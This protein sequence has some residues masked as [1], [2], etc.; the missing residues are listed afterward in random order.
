VPGGTSTAALPAGP[1]ATIHTLALVDT[2]GYAD[3]AACAQRLDA[4]E[5][6]HLAMPLF[7]SPDEFSSSLD[8]FP[9][10]YGAIISSHLALVGDDPFSGIAVQ[11]D[12]VRRA[13][14]VQAKSHVIHLREGFLQAGGSGLKVSRLIAHSISSFHTLLTNLA[15]LDRQDASTMDA[16]ARYAESHAGLSASLVSRLL[17]LPERDP[18]TADEAM[19]WYP[20]YLDASEAL[21]RFVDGWKETAGA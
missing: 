7:L 15:L 19:Q 1:D 13:C 4:W 21:A 18:L 10:E 3:L 9:L 6:L 16:L 2:L 8:V 11:R 14:E 17:T 12:D 5:S 20:P